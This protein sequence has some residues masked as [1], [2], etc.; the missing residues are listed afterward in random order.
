MAD[1]EPGWVQLRLWCAAYGRGYTLIANDDPKT[2]RHPRGM[3]GASVHAQ[4]CEGLV[5]EAVPNIDSLHAIAHEIA[6]SEAAERHGDDASFSR[7]VGVL[8]EQ[9]SFLTRLAKALLRE[10]A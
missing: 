5:V 8:T 3:A 4:L 10:T 9:I 1:L 2:A 6:H 7:E